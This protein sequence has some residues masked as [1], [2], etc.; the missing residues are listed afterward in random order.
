MSHRETFYQYLWAEWGSMFHHGFGV[1]DG[2]VNMVLSI[3][4]A[5]RG[6]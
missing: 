6:E 3:R 1:A 4:R 2:Y 5:L